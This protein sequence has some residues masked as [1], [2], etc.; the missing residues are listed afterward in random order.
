MFESSLPSV[1]DPPDIRAP[2]LLRACE[3]GLQ[4][5]CTPVH[6]FQ[7]AVRVC[8]RLRLR[9]QSCIAFLAAECHLFR[10]QTHR[11]RK[12]DLLPLLHK[13]KNVAGFAAAKAMEELPRGVHGERRRLF[14]MKR[15]QANKILPTGFLELDVVANHADNVRLLPH[16]FFETAESGHERFTSFCLKS[17]RRG[18]PELWCKCGGCRRDNP[19]PLSILSEHEQPVG[20]RASRRTPRKCPWP[21]SPSRLPTS[22][23]KNR[24]TSCPFLHL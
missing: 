10:H 23:H 15:A 12:A 18:M 20:A 7:S 22:S 14:S 2:A 8:P 17:R 4:R 11:L 5:T 9:S 24:Y 6:A 13:L 3:A 21:C 16:R 1:R 19:L